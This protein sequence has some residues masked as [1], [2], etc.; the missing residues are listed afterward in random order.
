MIWSV[1]KFQPAFLCCSIIEISFMY[2]CRIFPWDGIQRC[3]F[4]IISQKEMG[5]VYFFLLHCAARLLLSK[6]FVLFILWAY[7][8]LKGSSFVY[9]FKISKAISL[10]V[11]SFLL[12]T[13]W[14]YIEFIVQKRRQKGEVILKGARQKWEGKIW[15]LFLPKPISNNTNFFSNNLWFWTIQLSFC[16]SFSH[17]WPYLFLFWTVLV[18]FCCQFWQLHFFNNIF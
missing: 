7:C 2:Y 1:P 10:L 3:R 5:S 6:Y 18:P 4:V 12:F 9:F 17:S 13:E 16:S 8:S 14:G 15:K 11:F